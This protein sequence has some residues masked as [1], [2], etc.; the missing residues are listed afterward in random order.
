VVAQRLVRRI[1]R[2]CAT[3]YE[4]T[5]AEL[6]MYEKLGGAPK[7]RWVHGEGCQFCSGTGYYDRVGVY[8][9]LSITDEIRQCLVDGKPPRDARELAIQQGLRTLQHEAVRLVQYDI[10]T[11]EEVVKHVLVNEEI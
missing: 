11:M 3:V 1:C 7:E 8:E 10:T 4:P 6:T 5:L 2:S 9:V